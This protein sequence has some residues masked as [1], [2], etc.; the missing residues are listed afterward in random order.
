MHEFKRKLLFLSLVFLLLTLGPPAKAATFTVLNT[1]DAGAGSLRQAIID[2]EANPGFDI[3]VFDG[4]LSGTINLASNLPIIT[5]TLNIDGTTADDAGIGPDIRLDGTG[6]DY[7]LQFNGSNGH[8]IK[9]LQFQN[10]TVGVYI[11]SLTSGLTLGGGGQDE[12]TEIVGTDQGV[13]IDGAENVT[14]IGNSIGP[15]DP[16]RIGVYIT[17]D[18]SLVYIGGDSPSETNVISNNTEEGIYIEE[19][20]AVQI[21]RNYIGV[22]E[23]GTIDIGNGE[24]GIFVGANVTDLIIGTSDGEDDGNVIS[25][26]TGDGIYIFGSD[27]VNVLQNTIGLNGTSAAALPNGGDGIRIETSDNVIGAEGLGNIISG[28]TGNGIGIYNAGSNENQITGNIIGFLSDGEGD[29]GNGDNGIYIEGDSTTIVSN[30][31]GHSGLNG[32]QF[33]SATSATIQSNFIGLEGDGA[34][35][36]AN[37]GQAIYIHLS[38]LILIGDSALGSENSIYSSG[39]EPNVEI[40]GNAADFNTVR[41]NI[42]VGDESPIE[43]TNGANENLTNADITIT[44][45]NTSLVAGTS[46]QADDSEVDIYIDGEPFDSALVSD[47]EWEIHSAYTL[48]AEIFAV[49]TIAS[50]SSSENSARVEIVADEEA[51]SPP[52]ITSDISPTTSSSILLEGTKDAYSSVILNGVEIIALNASTTWS[53]TLNLDRGENPV[54]LTS[55]D[56]SDNVSIEN[57]YTIE[58]QTGAGG[59]GDGPDDDDEDNEDDDSEEEDPDEE[60]NDPGDEEDDDENDFVGTCNADLLEFPDTPKDFENNEEDPETPPTD[61]TDEEPSEE[62]VVEDPVEEPTTDPTIPSEDPI[63]SPPPVDPIDSVP[64]TDFDPQDPTETPPVEEPIQE[65]IVFDPLIWSEIASSVLVGGLTEEQLPVVLLDLYGDLDP[66]T[67]IDED[68]LL[69]G[70]ELIHGTSPE[71]KD[72]DEDGLSDYTEITEMGTSPIRWDTDLDGLSDLLDETPI[73]YTPTEITDEEAIDY[74]EDRGLILQDDQTLGTIDPDLD[75]LSN[76]QEI[77][78][79]TNPCDPDSDDDGYL[80]GEE[81]LNYDTDPNVVSTIDKIV[82]SNFRDE[83]TVPEGN[84]FF[85]GTASENTMVEIY[86]ITDEEGYTLWLG[87]TMTDETGKFA[88]YTEPLA[89]GDYAIVVTSMDE[90]HNV[91]NMSYPFHIKVKRDTGISF[92]HFLNI[93]WEANGAPVI[94]GIS[95]V[96]N[97]KLI[98]TWQSLVLSNTIIIDNAGQEFEI[99]APRQLELGQHTVT[100]YAVDNATG[101]KSAPIQIPFTIGEVNLTEP[102]FQKP[103]WTLALGITGIALIGT[104]FSLRRRVPQ[105]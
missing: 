103:A 60:E 34:T 74:L 83:E 29:G 72:T 43:L 87:E 101:L 94:R 95:E 90:N 47:G 55:E 52:V 91:V 23:G 99:S 1:N 7:C 68:G 100:L 10:C 96:G 36:A 73:V 63:Y 20:D 18:A 17:G 12:G 6:E 102:F 69:N 38:E 24:S 79:G 41:N 51:P 77:F 86:A 19:A 49:V 26:N 76:E 4:T 66:Y 89:E 40:D 67:D 42:H 58:R 54:T 39:G 84:L 78:W 53:Y 61:P 75:G 104:L 81:V 30:I 33:E 92:P 44:T 45:A 25:G 80:D 82:I 50:G 15:N 46:T 37:V 64:P 59:S 5:Q 31:I 14:L 27:G 48:G 70:V 35:A 9:A 22:N 2:A 28:N 97:I 88:L 62:P 57:T 16:N 13:F 71:K 3:I 56:Y 85:L 98:V 11:N 21:I 105:A 32:I 65:T 93:S 8:V